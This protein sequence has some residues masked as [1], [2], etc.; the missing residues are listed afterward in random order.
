MRKLIAMGALALM[1]T[2]CSAIKTVTGL[3]VTQQQVAVA[4]QAFDAVE[5]TATNYLSLPSCTT[6]Q[7]TLA[8]ACKN[9]K[10]VTKL[11]ADVKA[12][13]AA[14]DSLWNASQAATQGVG[15]IDLY[16]AVNAAVT[17]IHADL[18]S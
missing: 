5:E 17:A 11:I 12:G 8:N 6:G 15:A 9:P 2:G 14:R 7:T 3:A 16:N 13:R 10:A 4:V 1:L 18:Q